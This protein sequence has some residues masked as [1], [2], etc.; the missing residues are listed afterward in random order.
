MRSSRII[1][2]IAVIAIA[3]ILINIGYAFNGNARTY[4]SDDSN[5]VQYITVGLGDT[6]YSSAVTSEMKY[7]TDILVDSNGRSLVYIPDHGTTI[8]VSE[9]T[10]AVTEGV[11]FDISLSKESSDPMPTYTLSVSVD[12]SSKMHG[13]FYASYW[14]DPSNDNTR[15]N[16]AFP[17]SGI[18]IGNLTT[19]SIKFCLYVHAEE[20]VNEP[21]EP[22]DDIAF[23]FRTTVGV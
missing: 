23:K 12:D 13:T 10:Y 5:D 8:T 3:L 20:S 15:V 9:V 6:Q 19:Q 18:E 22:L 16:I 17:G 21:D 11:Q 1:A 2:G 7:H 14:T 4:N